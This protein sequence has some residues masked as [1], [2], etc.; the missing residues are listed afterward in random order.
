[1]NIRLPNMEMNEKTDGWAKSLLK[2]LLR[3]VLVVFGFFFVFFAY[4]SKLTKLTHVNSEPNDSGV[5]HADAPSCGD[6]S[7]DSSGGDSNATAGDSSDSGD[8][9]DSGDSGK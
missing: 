3:P 9:S 5:A 8:A 6:S 4:D 7:G 1:M 2:K